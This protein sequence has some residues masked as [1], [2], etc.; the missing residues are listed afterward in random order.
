MPRPNPYHLHPTPTSQI[1]LR[2]INK[3]DLLRTRLNRRSTLL[4]ILLTPQLNSRNNNISSNFNNISLVF[5]NT[6]MPS[7]LPRRTLNLNLSLQLLHL[8][9][10]FH[11]GSK[12]RWT[13]SLGIKPL[14]MVKVAAKDSVVPTLKTLYKP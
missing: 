11:Q 8:V 12:L 1:L 2:Q 4:I 13:L 3:C 14:R 10:I 9:K 6:R 7:R 5:S